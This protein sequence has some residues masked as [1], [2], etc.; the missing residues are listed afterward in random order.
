MVITLGSIGISQTSIGQIQTID[1]TGAE[2]TPVEVVRAVA[3]I[4]V[5][6]PIT[7][8]RSSVVED[9]LSNIGAFSGAS[10][11]RDWQQRAVAIQVIEK[12][13]KIG[14]RSANGFWIISQDGTVLA[15]SETS[16]SVEVIDGPPTEQIIGELV[17]GYPANLIEVISTLET[18]SLSADQLEVDAE[19]SISIAYA[20]LGVCLLYTSPSPRDRTRSRMP[21]SA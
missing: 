3:Q 17:T 4:Q 2:L 10:V 14:S 15:E 8:F 5:G 11:T 21:S 13:P 12:A 1:V 20:P 9:R 18:S 19:G 7:N 16:L 6:E